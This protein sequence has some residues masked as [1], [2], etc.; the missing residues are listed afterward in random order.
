MTQTQRVTQAT[1]APLDRLLS[2]AI[3]EAQRLR[4]AAGR[5]PLDP[6][7]EALR[8]ELMGLLVALKNGR[9]YLEGNVS[10]APRG[11]AP[12]PVRSPR[13]HPAHVKLILGLLLTRDG[14]EELLEADRRGELTHAHACED[15]PGE[16]C[17]GCS[18]DEILQ[19]AYGLSHQAS[20]Y[21]NLLFNETRGVG[22]N[23]ERLRRYAREHL[24]PGP[25]EIAGAILAAVDAEEEPVDA[26]AALIAS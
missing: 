20:L 22:E 4:Q 19:V 15:Q 2:E 8:D 9:A 1:V 3:A 26:D 13:T 18:N 12:A 14:A 6:L 11:E 17:A 21:E 16:D 25:E 10:P 23:A 24:L 5:E 7:T